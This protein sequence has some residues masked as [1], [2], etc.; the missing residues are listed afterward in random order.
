VL[1]RGL[2]SLHYLGSDKERL[3]AAT[4]FKSLWAACKQLEGPSGKVFYKRQRTKFYE[5]LRYGRLA[6]EMLEQGIELPTKEAQ[7]RALN[8]YKMVPFDL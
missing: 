7:Y 8:L 5:F 6:A 4:G 2:L 1:Q 3:K